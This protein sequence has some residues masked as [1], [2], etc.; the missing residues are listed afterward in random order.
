MDI[1][2][3]NKFKQT[4]L[5]VIIGI[6]LFA[7][8][9]NLSEVLGVLQYAIGLCMPLIVGGAM[10]FI[11]NVPMHFFEKQIDR[12]QR[13][14]YSKGLEKVK[15]AICIIVTLVTFPQP[16]RSHKRDRRCRTAVISKMD[17][18]P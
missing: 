12:L 17:R 11:M 3:D 15:T 1:K 8:L 5:I 7:A 14:H 18:D 2:P 10:A 6:M 4:L 9:L 13:R 16:G